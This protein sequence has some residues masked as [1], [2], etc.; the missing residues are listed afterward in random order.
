MGEWSNENGRGKCDV[1][2]DRQG[3]GNV[4]RECLLREM[5]LDDEKE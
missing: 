3:E 1:G 4:M 5:N 2:G